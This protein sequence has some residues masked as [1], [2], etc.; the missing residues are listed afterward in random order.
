MKITS[1][2][3]RL[4]CIILGPL[5]LISIAAGVWQFKNATAR[6][7]EIFD[8]GLL[9][10]A[11]AISRDMSVTGGDALGQPTRA[12]I[13]NTSGGEVFYH[14]H[15]PDGVFVTGYATPPVLSNS[16]ISSF[17]EPTY[18]NSV[19]QRRDVRV[20]RVQDTATIGAVTGLF[21]FTVW[22]NAEVRRAFV[23]DVVKRSFAVIALLIASVGL[24][25]WFGVNLGLR[26]LLDL[27]DAVAE[28]SPSELQPIQRAVPAEIRGLVATL[29]ALL[30]RVSRRISSKDEFISNAAHQMRNPI[31]GVLALA[32]S[33]QSAPTSEAM[34]TR[35]AELV[36]AAR[37]ASHLTNQLLSFE[38]AKGTET[39]ETMKPHDLTQL[40][41]NSVDAF[42]SKIAQ[43]EIDISC[44]VPNV[45]TLV[46][47]DPVM[48]RET[49][50]NLLNNAVLHGG[51]GL[52][53]IDVTLA[54]LDPEKVS[55]TIADD[56]I[57]IAPKDR[58][59]VKIRFGQAVG[60]NGSGLGLP[61]AIKVVETMGGQ[62]EILDSKSGLMI[63]MKIPRFVADG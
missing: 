13:S 3:T 58:S 59:L 14:V 38:R 27:Q 52:S 43:S 53:R 11:L 63:E 9:S 51:V 45:E 6:A 17:Q 25:V 28:R 33:V 60:S 57:G 37:H 12:L 30:D 23:Q 50:I 44:T 16:I 54:E 21:T 61:I 46:L 62:F 19:Y 35:S 20:L 55:L 22:Q 39:T 31:A 48:M 34:R 42:A 1:L 29:N 26:P 8:R 40:V 32:E 18:S 5:L 15:A 41:A 4:I 36:E 56:G 47:C 49:V 7:Q 2:R 10:A 24:V